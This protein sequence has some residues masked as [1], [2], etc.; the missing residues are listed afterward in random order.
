MLTVSEYRDL[1]AVADIHDVWRELWWKTPQASFVQSVEWYERHCRRA[2]DTQRPRVFLVALAGRPVG[3][4]PWVEK[5]VLSRV[6][7]VRVLSDPLADHGFFHGPLGSKPELALEAALDHAQSDGRWDLLE[8]RHVELRRSDPMR[9]VHRIDRPGTAGKVE[10]SRVMVECRGDWVRYLRSRSDDVREKYQRSERTLCERGKLEHVRYRPEGTPLDDDDPRWDLFSEIERAEFGSYAKSDARRSLREM[11]AS[12]SASASVDLN[13]LRL[14]GKP[15]AW[16]YNYRCDGRIEM[17]RMRVTRE[18]SSEF[19]SVAGCVLLGR[20]LC[21]GFRR[22]DESYLFDRQTSRTA[23]GW[24]TS[25]ATSRR[26][27]HFSRRG[28]RA[29]FARFLGGFTR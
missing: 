11:H 16:A 13:L 29:K 6:G 4:V 24:Q 15:I 14:D 9:G 5:T 2:G 1:S 7:R 20:M 10:E 19:S 23:G 25:Q 27:L 18:F 26:R 21:D 12:A 17:Q 22:G 28:A 3:L 8:L